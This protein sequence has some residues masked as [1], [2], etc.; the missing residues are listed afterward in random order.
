MNKFTSH[1]GIAVPLMA[2]NIDTD[3]IIPSR[4]M[5][6]VSKIGLAEGLFS[7]QKY[8]YEGNT[9]IGLNPD[10]ILNSSKYKDSSII[11][12]GKNF[13]CGSSRE[14]AVWALFEYGFKAIIAQSFGEIF[15]LN[16]MRNHLLPIQLS[17]REIA[18]LVEQTSSDPVNN[19]LSIDLRKRQLLSP[20]GK[21]LQFELEQP[22]Q[23]MLLMGWDFIDMALQRQDQIDQF[24]GSDRSLRNWAHL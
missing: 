6:K 17:E 22:Y 9:K 21:R 24:I 18:Y 15:R 4:E 13:G 3:Q 10:F 14:H 8:L 19:S 16:C 11:L 1:T 12:S 20:C 7:G 23:E 5:K 2:D